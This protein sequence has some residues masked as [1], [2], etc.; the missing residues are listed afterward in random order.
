MA[1]ATARRGSVAPGHL[2]V[3]GRRTLGA[4][5]FGVILAAW[6]LVAPVL[7]SAAPLNDNYASRLTLQLAFADTRSN[8]G[9]TNEAS[10]PL[11]PNDPA[12]LGCSKGG[13]QTTGGVKST[14]TL[15]WEFTGNGGPITVSTNGSNFDT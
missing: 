7:A 5:T 1:F 14:G 15:W 10:E 2:R 8:S 3:A 13:A 4:L 9:A 12:N 11:T 6:P